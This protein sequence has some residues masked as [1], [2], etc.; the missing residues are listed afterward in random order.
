MGF[1]LVLIQQV[2]LSVCLSVTVGQ[3]GGA[4]HKRGSGSSTTSSGIQWMDGAL[5]GAESL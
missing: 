3:H 5:V 2:Y 4:G 1:T